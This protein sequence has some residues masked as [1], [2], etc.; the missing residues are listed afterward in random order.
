[1]F[2]MFFVMSMMHD[3]MFSRT[4]EGDSKPKEKE[5]PKGYYECIDCGE[6]CKRASS[7]QVRCKECQMIHKRELDRQRKKK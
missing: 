3:I 7:S 5:I 2:L 4:F 6:I 1:M